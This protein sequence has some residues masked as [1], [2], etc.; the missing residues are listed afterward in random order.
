MTATEFLEKNRELILAKEKLF[1]H[2]V[3]SVVIEKPKL[4]VWMILIP[5]FFVF[6]F[7]QLSR[8]SEGR[9]D[10]AH[11]FL[12]SRERALNCAF[13]AA[14]SKS[15]PVL[16]PVID[17]VGLSDTARQKY[18]EWMTLLTHHYLKLIQGKGGN[19]KELVHAS[20]ADETELQQFYDRLNQVEREFNSSLSSEM[21]TPDTETPGVL[22]KIDDAVIQLRIQEIKYVFS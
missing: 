14:K 19:Y 16:E 3:S 13:E 7:W 5:V 8:Y 18:S 22:K 15:A 9:K 10:F 4:G 17:G 21:D 2:Q 11:N 12:L 6:Y 1:C 20:F